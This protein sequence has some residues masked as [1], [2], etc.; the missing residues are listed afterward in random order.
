[1][2][3][4][5]ARTADVLEQ[6]AGSELLVYDL[7][8]NKAYILNETLMIV[9]K[10]CG[11]QSF[12]DLKRRYKFTDELVHFALGELER[13]NLLENYRSS[14]FSGMSRREVVKKVGLA[15]I[16]ALPVITG[17]IAPKPIHA[18]SND[19]CPGCCDEVE[20]P[21]A[22][23]Q[24]ENDQVCDPSTGN[25][26]TTFKTAGTPC[27]DGNAATTGDVCDGSGNCIGT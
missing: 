11:E 23:T 10:A 7:Q 20:C 27:D 21:Y 1:M 17:L 5:N 6:D 13:N 18:A 12:E 3:L 9:Y 4:P 24:C 19:P 15:T 2:N 16:A 8:I 14:Y 22:Q 26:V 25:C